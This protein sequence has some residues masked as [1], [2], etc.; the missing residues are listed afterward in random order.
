M[1]IN[2]VKYTNIIYAAKDGP[3]DAKSLAPN[4][5]SLKSE[6]YWEDLA[7]GKPY[8][9]NGQLFSTEDGHIYQLIDVNNWTND[10]G[11]KEINSGVSD[12][13]IDVTP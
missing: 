6:I 12:G 9:K 11:W 8:I 1:G 3:L 4:Y 10:N 7:N 13:W 2:G 5:E